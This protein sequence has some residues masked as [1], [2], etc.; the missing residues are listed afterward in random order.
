MTLK[1]FY[2]L[3]YLQDR[4]ILTRNSFYATKMREMWLFAEQI[5]I[6]Q[7]RIGKIVF[8]QHYFK[9]DAKT[10]SNTITRL[11]VQLERA[12]TSQ[13]LVTI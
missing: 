10:L 3:L 9:A 7:G 6:V 5:D 4:C 2:N 12:L 11:L 8:L 13:L 1:C